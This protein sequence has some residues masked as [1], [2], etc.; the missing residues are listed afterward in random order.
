MHG[1]GKPWN[2]RADGDEALSGSRRREIKYEA[3]YAARTPVI[4]SDLDQQTRT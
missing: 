2:H 1:E 4:S 3:M